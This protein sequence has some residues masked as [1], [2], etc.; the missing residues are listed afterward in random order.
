MFDWRAAMLYI[1]V[2]S[3]QRWPFLHPPSILFGLD[4]HGQEWQFNHLKTVG[5]LFIVFYNKNMYNLQTTLQ[6]QYLCILLYSP[7]GGFSGI[8]PNMY[9]VIAATTL[10]FIG[11]VRHGRGEGWVHN[12]QKPIFVTHS[13]TG[14]L[15]RGMHFWIVFIYSTYSTYP[16][17]SLWSLLYL[18][19]FSESS[20]KNI[21]KLFVKNIYVE[22]LYSIT[23]RESSQ[24]HINNC[25]S[26][27]LAN[28]YFIIICIQKWNN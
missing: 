23:A 14:V 24:E 10:Q 6:L 25:F 7:L 1:C 22:Y 26:T 17:N 13:L 19:R 5:G 18:G 11:G 27:Q 20:P 12:S 8:T 28:F 9:P 4:V 3:V 2:R 21:R 16:D 15:L